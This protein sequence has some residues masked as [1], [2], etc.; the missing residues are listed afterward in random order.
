MAILRSESLLPR[1]RGPR[2]GPTIRLRCRRVNRPPLSGAAAD[3]QLGGGEVFER[4][5]DRFE[6]RDL[7]GA[8]PA[9][10]CA[11]R[12]AEQV[13]GDP[14]RREQAGLQ[15]LDDVTGLV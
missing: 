9:V 3:R 1:R 2:T 7:V 5:A 6:Q 12:E 14:V 15:R 4:G 13:A 11:A 10:A 8:A